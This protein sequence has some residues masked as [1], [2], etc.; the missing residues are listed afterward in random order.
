MF[1]C[2]NKLLFLT[3]D[4]GDRTPFPFVIEKKRSKSK[5][6]GEIEKH[7]FYV[8]RISKTTRTEK[9]KYFWKS[10]LLLIFLQG[11]VRI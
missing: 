10:I 3:S 8:E 7:K 1:I 9:K 5:E 4:F 2:N 6:S 11:R